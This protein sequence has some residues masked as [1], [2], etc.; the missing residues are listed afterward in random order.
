VKFLGHMVGADGVRPL[1]S[2]VEALAA[3]PRPTTIKELQRFLGIINFYR[4]FLPGIA[5]T[6]RPLT[7]ALRGGA[8]SLEW[9]PPMA[10]AF[11]AAKAALATATPLSHPQP[12]AT[13][14]VFCD[15]SLALFYSSLRSAAAVGSRSRFFRA[16]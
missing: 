4:R 12:D 8:K 16:S 6:L 15:A 2:Q 3:F 5:A 11:D 9:S 14:S 13:V 1:G 10:T 7:N